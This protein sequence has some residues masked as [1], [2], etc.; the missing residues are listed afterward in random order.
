MA[1]M[2]MRRPRFHRWLTAA[3]YLEAINTRLL[4]TTRTCSTGKPCKGCYTTTAATLPALH[5]H[6]PNNIYHL[7]YSKTTAAVA[8]PHAT[9]GRKYNDRCCIKNVNTKRSLHFLPSRVSG[10]P[11]YIINIIIVLC[12][13]PLFYLVPFLVAHTYY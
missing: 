9:W 5:H 4:A 7:Q 11:Y 1:I 2:L 8:V 12:S 13:G 6:T 3:Y 10:I